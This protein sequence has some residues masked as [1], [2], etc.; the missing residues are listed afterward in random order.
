MPLA[1][2]GFLWSRWE[3]AEGDE[4]EEAAGAT[5]ADVLV[6]LVVAVVEEEAVF[7]EALGRGAEGGESAEGDR[8]RER[9]PPALGFT[10][11][12]V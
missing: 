10:K 3:A 2:A 11:E 6:V 12:R 5:A 4:E 8:D 9:L 7:A 1:L